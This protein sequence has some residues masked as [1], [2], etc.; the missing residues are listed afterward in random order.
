LENKI[1]VMT[2][3]YSLIS[4][5]LKANY[6]SS[7]D[8]FSR[9][10]TEYGAAILLPLLLTLPHLS[11]CLKEVYQREHRAL[12]RRMTVARESLSAAEESEKMYQARYASL[13]SELEAVSSRVSA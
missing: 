13:R 4:E 1:A 10:A 7:F 8:S 5:K 11:G 12:Q 2:Q 9:T 6:L 3:G